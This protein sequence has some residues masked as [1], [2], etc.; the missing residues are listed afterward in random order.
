MYKRIKARQH[1]QKT[2]GSERQQQ[3]HN[4]EMTIGGG[5]HHQHQHQHLQADFKNTFQPE[6]V[7]ILLLKEEKNAI[8]IPL[9]TV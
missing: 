3:H 2:A 4:D 5:H 1:Q 7:Y 8:T 9:A 6:D